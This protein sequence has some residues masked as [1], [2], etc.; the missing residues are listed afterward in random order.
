MVESLSRRELQGTTRSSSPATLPVIP[1]GRLLAVAT[2]GDQPSPSATPETPS[3]S[4][5]LHG[6]RGRHPSWESASESFCPESSSPALSS[7]V[8]VTVPASPPSLVTSL[9]TVSAPRPKKRRRRG[10]SGSP[11][12]PPPE[13]AM[14]LQPAAEVKSAV[15]GP[16]AVS[17][18]PILATRDIVLQPA[19]ECAVSQ[20]AV[21]TSI[22][23]T[24]TVNVISESSVMS[25]EEKAAADSAAKAV[26]ESVSARQEMPVIITAKTLSE[27]LSRLAR[28]LD[29]PVSPVLSPVPVPNAPEST[30]LKSTAESHDRS[31]TAVSSGPKPVAVSADPR[32]AAR[33]SDPQSAAFDASTEFEV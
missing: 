5:N 18:V 27:Y 23:E 26:I 14:A 31:P 10:A 11:S 13:S 30:D 21:G 16:A 32:P 2:L 24:C 6:K 1:E 33:G 22:P 28:I 7:P 29:V 8:P 20:S 19:A 17:A 4:I 9:A 12:L 15:P 3:T 25:A